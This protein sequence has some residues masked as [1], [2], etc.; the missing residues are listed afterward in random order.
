M[1]IPKGFAHGYL[2]LEPN[3]LMQWCVDEDFC[4]EAAKCLRWDSCGIDWLGNAE[5]YVISEN[6]KN[7]IEIINLC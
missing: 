6:N 1:Y 3:T 4:A 5:E 2:T 7:S